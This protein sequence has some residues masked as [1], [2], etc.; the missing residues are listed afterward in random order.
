[1]K[2]SYQLIPLK[3]ANIYPSRA[4]I[5]YSMSDMGEDEDDDFTLKTGTSSNWINTRDDILTIDNGLNNNLFTKNIL[6]NLD[7]NQIIVL[8]SSLYSRSISSTIQYWILF[9]LFSIISVVYPLCEFESNKGDFNFIPFGVGNYVKIFAKYVNMF[10][11]SKIRQQ[12][13]QLNKGKTGTP[14]KKDN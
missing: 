12:I 14:N 2:F 13:A 4:N 1:M 7:N 10:V 3:I 5:T 9:V 6:N 8:S 11:V